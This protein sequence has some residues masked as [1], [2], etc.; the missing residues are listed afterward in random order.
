MMGLEPKTVVA[1]LTSL[2]F[3][4]YILH[5]FAQLHKK[6]VA[7]F[8]YCVATHLLGVL[9]RG[10]G[11]SVDCGFLWI[12]FPPVARLMVMGACGAAAAV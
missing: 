10:W 1:F 7:P 6:Y 12:I 11:R 8:Y 2:L 3:F 9:F 5:F 4:S